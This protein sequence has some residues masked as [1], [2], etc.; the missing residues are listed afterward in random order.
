GGPT[1][2]GTP[3]SDLD[4]ASMG[5]AGTAV[6]QLVAGLADAPSIDPPGPPVLFLGDRIA[7]GWLVQLALVALLAPVVACV[8]DLTARLRRRHVPL[9]PGL[10]AVAWRGSTWLTALVVMWALTFLPGRL[11]SPVATV[12]LAGHTGVTDAG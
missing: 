7:Q 1:G 3:V 11:L 2:P 5:R 4:A 8:F 12:P 6:A 9:A 10:R